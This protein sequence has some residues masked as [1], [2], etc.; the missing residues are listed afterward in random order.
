MAAFFV[1]SDSPNFHGHA[2]VH[3]AMAIPI[4]FVSLLAVRLPEAR[5]T[6]RRM[7]RLFLTIVLLVLAASSLL[8]GAGAFASSGTGVADVLLEPLHG[9]GEAGTL[10]SV[11]S[12]PLSLAIVTAV[13]VVA[14]IRVVIGRLDRTKRPLHP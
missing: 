13:Y 9:L 8:E 10:F 12:L 4:V 5:T 1:G 7:A 14:G 2:I 6:P 11:F 3:W